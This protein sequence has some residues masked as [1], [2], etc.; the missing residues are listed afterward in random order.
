MEPISL[1]DTRMVEKQLGRAPRGLV[2][3]AR[4]CRYGYPQVVIVYPLVEGKPFP[5]TYWLTCPFLC[6]AIDRLEAQGW[7]KQA[8]ARAESDEAFRNDLERAHRRYI[9]ARLHLL[10]RED[11]MCLRRTGMLRDLAE[12]GIGGIADFARVKCL[13]LHVA[14]AL[15]DANPVGAMALQQLKKRDFPPQN[16]ICSAL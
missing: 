6:K 14:H 8:T 5:S 10:T 1:A 9:A 13:H 15:V 16:V 4:R 7:I 2:G 12:K 11:R 3:V